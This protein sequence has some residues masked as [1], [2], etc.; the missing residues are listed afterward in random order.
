MLS[1]IKDCQ[2]L[3]KKT[4][5]TQNLTIAR[6]LLSYLCCHLHSLHCIFIYYLYA[7]S[8]LYFHSLSL[9][10]LS[11]VFPF[12]IFM[13]SL[14]CISIHY[15]YAFYPLYFHLLSLCIL[16]I[17]FPFTIFMLINVLIVL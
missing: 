7:F 5:R 15:R 4:R 17:V 16:S 14:H 12:T 2:R 10:I 9:C 6:S 1:D 11:I 13:H 8:P 3:N